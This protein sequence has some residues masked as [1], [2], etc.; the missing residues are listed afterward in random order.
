MTFTVNVL[1][2]FILYRGA[3]PAMIRTVFSRVSHLPSYVFLL[4]RLALLRERY[5]VC[6]E[7]FFYLFFSQASERAGCLNPRV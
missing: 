6:L 2:T 5:Y 1:L 7:K 4:R 3:G